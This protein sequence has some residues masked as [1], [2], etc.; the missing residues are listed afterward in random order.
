ML[1]DLNQSHNPVNDLDIAAYAFP[2]LYTHERGP[3]LSGRCEADCLNA[4]SEMVG[5]VKY[6]NGSGDGRII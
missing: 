4:A 6:T 3:L 2:R 5:K 1:I